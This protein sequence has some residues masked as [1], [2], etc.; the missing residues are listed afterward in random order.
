MKLPRLVIVVVSV[1]SAA[2]SAETVDDVKHHFSF[3][4]PAGYSR[5]AEADAPG[6]FHAFSRAPAAGTSWAALSIVPL[7]G[8][9]AQ[10]SKLNH[11]IA[12]GAAKKE[13]ATSGLEL[14]GFE[15]RQ[16]TWN[17][18]PLEVMLT[19]ATSRDAKAVTLATQVPLIGGAIQ[20]QLVGDAA[21]EAKLFA[22]FT[23]VITSLRGETNWQMTIGQS[24]ELG[25]QVGFVTGL[26]CMPVCGLGC[27]GLL[28]WW[29]VRRRPGK[30]TKQ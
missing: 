24:R 13:A 1:L 25:E 10:N 2:V 22:E 23:A 18:F 26:V 3:E 4:I 14:T 8:T 27:V 5:L 19:R 28:V 11:A 30:T 7:G 16:I 20:V 6:A 12:E 21:D 29:V 15:Y 9:I 17:D